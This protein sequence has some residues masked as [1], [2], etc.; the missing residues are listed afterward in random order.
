[1]G[2]VQ[3]LETININIKL[4]LG[5][6]TIS[7]S[8]FC[9]SHQS[10]FCFSTRYTQ[11]RIL[12]RLYSLFSASVVEPLLFLSLSASPPHSLWYS[13]NIVAV[14]P[15]ICTK[16]IFYIC[17][18]NQLTCLISMQLFKYISRLII[19]VYWP[20]SIIWSENDIFIIYE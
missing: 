13:M 11:R 2:Q 6:T 4:Q 8:S 12:S 9:I 19:F 17:V 20:C 10:L 14:H 15:R 7:F 18:F 1:M 5:W 16:C 3:S